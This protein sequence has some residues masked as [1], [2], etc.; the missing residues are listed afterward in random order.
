MALR[1]E[2]NVFITSIFVIAFLS[3]SLINGDQSDEDYDGYIDNAS[4]VMST[5]KTSIVRPDVSIAIIRSGGSV[6]V[7]VSRLEAIGYTNISLISYLSGLDSISKYEILILPATWAGTSGN[8]TDIMANDSDYVEY[9]NNGGSL[10]IQQPNANGTVTVD[11]T[12]LP[13]PVIF[14]YGYN[15][16]D[17]PVIVDTTHSISVGLPNVGMPFSADIISSPLHPMYHV[18]CR[19]S[20][21]SSPSLFVAEYGMGKILVETLGFHPGALLPVSDTVIVRMMDWLSGDAVTAFSDA[22]HDLPGQFNLNQNYPNPFNPET[23]I[24]YN[25][26]ETTYTKLVIYNSVGQK[27]RTLVS[28]IQSPGAHS[29]IWNSTNEFGEILSSGIYYYKLETKEFTST[30]KMLLI[31]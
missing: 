26:G 7:T 13:E 8:A 11:V 17:L 5:H 6:D 28:G 30:K 14:D 3:L 10:M 18:I 4:F 29:V 15:L 27:V 2:K 22:N 31:K 21:S 9:V 16:S 25:L 19:G 1:A 24:E 12:L 23:L 20:I